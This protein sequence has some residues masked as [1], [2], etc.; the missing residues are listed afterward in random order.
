[1]TIDETIREIKQRWG[2]VEAF[3]ACI[4][5]FKATDNL[6][7]LTFR[8]INAFGDALRKQGFKI[9]RVEPEE[10]DRV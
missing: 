2:S 3:G 5:A 1:M 7:E 4:Q 8:D 6:F 10:T 9:V